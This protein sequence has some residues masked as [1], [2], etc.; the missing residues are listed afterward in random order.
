MAR[1]LGRLGRSWGCPA[2]RSSVAKPLIDDL[3]NGQYVFAYFPDAAWLH[4]SPLLSCA[5]GGAPVAVERH[6]QALMADLDPR[7]ATALAA[8][9]GTE[10]RLL[11]ARA[12]LRSEARIADRW[13]WDE[14]QVRAFEQSPGKA[15]L[16]SAI[17]R[18]RA[19]F[20]AANPGHELF[21]NP[22]FRSL[23][24]QIG[25]WNDNESVARAGKD[26]LDVAN[27]AVA[28]PGFPGPGTPEGKRRFRQLLTTHK[29]EPPPTI[30]A[31]GLSLHGQMHAIDFQV[32]TKGR[33]VAG[34][35]SSTVAT[36]WDAAG[37]TTKLQEAVAAADAGFRGPLRAPYEPWHY[38]F[39]GSIRNDAR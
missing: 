19:S 32:Q 18:V 36:A 8:I 2:V 35:Q 30:A 1:K 10:R 17:A 31:P 33:I 26:L 24:V 25:H 21:V 9:N 4:N 16:D 20:A 39:V 6:L 22:A 34:P 14:Q 27:S 7:P 15:A 29:P 28:A 23:G 11:A 5:T 3:K 12:Y 38:D 13:S 37:W